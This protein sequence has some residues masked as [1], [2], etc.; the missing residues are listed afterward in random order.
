MLRQIWG[1]I[2]GKRY[3][4]VPNEEGVACETWPLKINTI[5]NIRSTQTSMERKISG[6]SLLDKINHTDI[7]EKIKFKLHIKHDVEMGWTCLENERQHIDNKIYKVG[8]TR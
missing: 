3:A 1:N 6:I 8:T 7:R 5:Q 4:N 2:S